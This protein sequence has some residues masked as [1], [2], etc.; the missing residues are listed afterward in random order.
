MFTVTDKAGEKL[1]RKGVEQE[2][3]TAREAFAFRSEYAGAVDSRDLADYI[4]V[5]MEDWQPV[6]GQ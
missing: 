6:A 1:K 5:D 3:D 4:V 2:F